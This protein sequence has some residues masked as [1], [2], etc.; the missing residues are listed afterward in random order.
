[1]RTRLCVVILSS[2]VLLVGHAASAQ[3]PALYAVNGVQDTLIRINTE[4]GRGR[5]VGPLGINIDGGGLDFACDGTLWAFSRSE[6]QVDVA[7]LYTIDID[8]GAATVVQT[9]D[10][11]GLPPGVGLEFGPDDQTLYWRTGTEL[12][13]LDPESGAIIPV[14]SS[15]SNNGSSLTMNPDTCADFY[16]T[17]RTRLIRIDPDDGAQSPVGNGA[18][19]YTALAAT[20]EGALYGHSA[21]TLYRIDTG[22]GAGLPIGQIGSPAPGLA[23]GPFGVT[24]AERCPFCPE[25]PQPEGQGYWHQQCAGVSPDGGGI[26]TDL[27]VEGPTEPGFVETLMPC[28][29]AYLQEL[30]FD[31]TSTCDG[32][33]A[34]PANDKCEK[35]LKQLTALI[36]NVCSDRL[37]EGCP[38]EVSTPGCDATRVGALIEETAALIHLGE[39]TQAVTC[40]DPVNSDN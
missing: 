16:S 11:A 28:A 12:L 5:V 6:T 9:F 37:V 17:A 35:A 21:R 32:M 38:T 10:V 26:A 24:C 22:T 25:D 23:Y 8:S 30:G 31:G 19:T 7:V 33:E 4:T 18:V 29:E 1:M 34:D 13:I 14:T 40:V 15:L 39:C 2:L 36:L 20:P 3:E 27:F